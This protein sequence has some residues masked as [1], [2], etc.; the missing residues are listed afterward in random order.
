MNRTGKKRQGCGFARAALQASSSAM[1][2]GTSFIQPSAPL[3]RERGRWAG[4]CRECAA[5]GSSTGNAESNALLPRREPREAI[6]ALDEGDERQGHQEERVG[7]GGFWCVR[8]GAGSRGEAGTE[9][10]ATSSPT[11]RRHSRAATPRASTPG[12]SAPDEPTPEGVSGR[13]PGGSPRGHGARQPVRQ[14][15]R[16]IGQLDRA[17]RERP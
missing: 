15:P 7:R 1:V 4:S 13:S 3:R 8:E 17:R 12:T 6:A 10:S 11:S 5:R 16:H 9:G 14:G 2:P